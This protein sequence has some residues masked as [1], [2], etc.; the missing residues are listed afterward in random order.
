MSRLYAMGNV[1]EFNRG[2]AM[3]IPSIKRQAEEVANL[4]ARK[5][6][7]VIGKYL[8]NTT[9]VGEFL[10]EM[11]CVVT[12]EH[13]SYFHTHANYLALGITAFCTS[14]S[15]DGSPVIREKEL[16]RLYGH[17]GMGHAL[18]KAMTIKSDLPGILKR[19]SA[20]TVAT[21]ESVAQFY[22][23]AL[24]DVIHGSH[25]LQRELDIAHKFEEIYQDIRAAELLEE[26][27]RIEN[28]YGI[29][30]LADTSFG[31]PIDSNVV[32]ARAEKIAQFALDPGKALRWVDSHKYNYDSEGNFSADM[33]SELRYCARPVDRALDEFR[34]LGIN[35]D[36]GGRKII[37][38]VLLT[39]FWTPQGYVDNARIRA[40]E[41]IK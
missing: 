19:D 9:S 41:H 12:T 24:I 13:R 21:D 37:D 23:R 17:E 27:L 4:A 6:H 15:V 14:S 20:L 22:E 30:V 34:K 29:C 3:D 33:I 10:R 2:L 31:N 39:G 5:Y 28:M 35:Y 25:D 36:E 8:Q 18:N 32:R 1:T 40:Q 26:H 16:I 38:P 11:E 7:K